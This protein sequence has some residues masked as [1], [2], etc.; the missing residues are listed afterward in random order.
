VP[1]LARRYA[2]ADGTD[3]GATRTSIEVTF[4]THRLPGVGV[5]EH[6]GSLMTGARE[7]VAHGASRV[8]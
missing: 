6:L 4:V 1:E 8:T 3:L 5:G 7:T 2:A